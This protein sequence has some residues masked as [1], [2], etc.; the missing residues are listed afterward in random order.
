MHAFKATV[1]ILCFSTETTN[2]LEHLHNVVIVALHSHE[3]K[4]LFV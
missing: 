3:I 1:S 4:S 2:A